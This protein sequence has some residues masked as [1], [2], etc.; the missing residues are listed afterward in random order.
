MRFL[1]SVINPAN[2]SLFVFS[3]LK[4]LDSEK[5]KV[6]EESFKKIMKLEMSSIELDLK[7]SEEKETLFINDVYKI[8]K[9]VQGDLLQVLDHANQNW[10][11]KL[12]NGSKGYFN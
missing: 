12:D 2:A 8:W 7:Y 6:L 9:E 4:T 3:F 10:D 5:K 11:K 1:E